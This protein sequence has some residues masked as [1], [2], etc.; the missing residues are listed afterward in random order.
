MMS[1]EDVVKRILL[2]RPDLSYKDVLKRI[3]EKKRDVEGYL[4]D[5]TAA[6]IVA[7]ELGVEVP[8]EFFKTETL[9][10][11]VV[12]G[13]NDVTVNGRII[14]V[15]LPQTFIRSD[16]SK[17]TIAHLL[18]TDKTGTIRV[19]LW[20]DKTQLV[21]TGKLAQGQIIKVSHGYIR[22]ARDGK[23]ELHVGSRGEIQVS[24]SNV[25]ESDLTK[26]AD[27][28]REGGPITVEGVVATTPKTTQ[29]I[30]ARNEKVMVTSFNLEDNTAKIRVSVWRKL[31]EVFK[32]IGVGTKVRI[33]NA[34]VKRGFA[35]QLELTSRR[36]TWIEIL[37]KKT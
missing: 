8:Q 17:G 25:K 12:P 28:R 7:T 26:V 1:L 22:E 34:Y 5:E 4:T 21:E 32:N 23:P 30:T 36:H 29:V 31:T 9:I 19:V 11:D 33:N 24:P 27:I 16:M 10:K 35:D 20:N 37:S 2:F 3:E 14:T 15:H 13:L 6:R 18:I